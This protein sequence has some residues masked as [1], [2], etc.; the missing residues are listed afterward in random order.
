MA[1]TPLCSTPAFPPSP[2]NF[3]FVPCNH[4][5]PKQANH[6]PQKL[7]SSP[8][9]RTRA[10]HCITLFRSPNVPSTVSFPSPSEIV[11]VT[12]S[13][14]ASYDSNTFRTIATCSSLSGGDAALALTPVS[15]GSWQCTTA[16]LPVIQP[17][18]L[19]YHNLPRLNL[20]STTRYC[21]PESSSIMSPLRNT[22]NQNS[23]LLHLFFPAGCRCFRLSKISSL[24]WYSIDPYRL[25]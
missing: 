20:L 3:S 21:P 9:T 22:K 10:T 8:A 15:Y 23:S 13:I 19:D 11:T 2:P 1:I 14:S 16:L 18:P 6:S 25:S 24:Y 5:Q 17:L 4:S 12:G 7:F